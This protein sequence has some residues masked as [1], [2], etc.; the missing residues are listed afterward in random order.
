LPAVVYSRQ[1][2]E[3]IVNICIRLKVDGR[4]ADIGMLK[5]VMTFW[6]LFAGCGN[7]R[8]PSG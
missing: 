1:I 3:R 5:T 6:R 7:P 8:L 4:R 2:P